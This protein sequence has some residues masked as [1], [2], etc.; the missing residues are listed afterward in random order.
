MALKVLIDNSVVSNRYAKATVIT[1]ADA[2]NGTYDINFDV[3][4]RFTESEKDELYRLFRKSVI[5][6]DVKWKIANITFLAPTVVSIL[7]RKDGD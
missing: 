1:N 5:G 3:N 4:S 7:V 6:S 2:A